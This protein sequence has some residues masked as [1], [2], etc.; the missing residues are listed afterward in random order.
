MAI[1][2]LFDRVAAVKAIIDWMAL[3][4]TYATSQIRWAYQDVNV[5]TRPYIVLNITSDSPAGNGFD[6]RTYSYEANVLTELVSGAR[7]LALSVNIYTDKPTATN[8]ETTRQAM[9]VAR[10]IKGAEQ[11]TS[12]RAVLSDAGLAL[13]EITGA[14]DLSELDG[15]QW[16]ARVGFD[17]RLAYSSNITEAPTAGTG[18]ISTIELTR[19]VEVGADTETVIMTLPE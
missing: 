12:A 6:E 10:D 1:V 4:S 11:M 7:E 16:V 18:W 13:L 14:Q 17:I 8:W 9:D 15:E 5:P 3:V 19:T 2:Q